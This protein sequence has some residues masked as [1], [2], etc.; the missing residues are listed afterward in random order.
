[1][2][3]ITTHAWLFSEKL[4]KLFLFKFGVNFFP[5]W[6]VFTE[7]FKEK[8]YLLPFTKKKKERKKKNREK[9]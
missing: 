2:L 1:M 8:F 9:L 7:N 4:T 5:V 3:Q 6:K